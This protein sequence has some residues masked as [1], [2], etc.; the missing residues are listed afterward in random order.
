MPLIIKMGK[1][2]AGVECTGASHPFQLEKWDDVDK[3]SQLVFQTD[4]RKARVCCVPVL[5]VL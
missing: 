4:V 5:F 2:M 1:Q 3:I